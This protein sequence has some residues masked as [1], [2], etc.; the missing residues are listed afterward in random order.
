MSTWTSWDVAAINQVYKLVPCP[1]STLYLGLPGITWDVPAKSQLATQ[2]RP[3]RPTSTWNYLG[4]TGM[5]KLG[6]RFTTLSLVPDVP[7]VPAIT[8]DVPGCPR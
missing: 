6:V 8:W 5:Y 3:R 2:P 1:M 4:H 7:F